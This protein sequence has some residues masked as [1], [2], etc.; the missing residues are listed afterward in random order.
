VKYSNFELHYQEGWELISLPLR[1]AGKK[2][3]DIFPEAESAYKYLNGSYVQTDI[4]KPGIGYCIRFSKNGSVKIVG[5]PFAEYQINLKPGCYLIGSTS[6][7]SVI[8]VTPEDAIEGIYQ[9]KDGEYE[10]INMLSPG[11]AYGCNPI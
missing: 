6:E 10:K 9:Y 8:E 4:L 5:E 7:E 3:I 1:P 11:K 2:L